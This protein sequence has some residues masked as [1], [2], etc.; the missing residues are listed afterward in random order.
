MNK[1]KKF[2]RDSHIWL[3]VVFA[4][5]LIVIGLTTTLLAFQQNFALDRYFVS[6]K[7]FPGYN[8]EKAGKKIELKAY[9]ENNDYKY[10]GYK[11]ALYIKLRDDEPKQVDFFNN[12]EIRKIGIY[13]GKL[14]VGTKNGLYMQ[15]GTTYENVLKKEIW[16]FFVSKDVHIVAKDSIY[17]CKNDF[18]ECKQEQQSIPTKPLGEIS[19]K[20][21]VLDLHTGKAL[22]GKSFE[23]IWQ[24]IFGVLVLFFVYSGFYLWYKKKF[25]Q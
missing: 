5:P 21:L 8:D 18:N 22:F 10:Y 13:D 4:I 12:M 1:L 20:Q 15:N 9:F 3:G 14:L 6:S 25:R 23:W 7:Y 19:I 16:D 24:V 11:N 2:L 17:V